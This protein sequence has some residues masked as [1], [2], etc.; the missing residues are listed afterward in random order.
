VAEPAITPLN[1][2]RDCVATPAK[3]VVYLAAPPAPSLTYRV[4]PT[5]E[6]QPADSFSRMQPVEVDSRSQAVVFANPLPVTI[7]GAWLEVQVLGLTPTPAT[8]FVQVRGELSPPNEPPVADKPPAA[9]GGPNV[10][11]PRGSNTLDWLATNQALFVVGLGLLALVVLGVVAM[12]L[13]STG[14]MGPIAAAA[15]GV[16]GS[17]TGAFFGVHAGLGDRE[18]VDNE[19]RL[20]ATKGQMLAAMVPSDDE[21]QRTALKI[22]EEYGPEMTGGGAPRPGD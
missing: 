13:A 22:M 8:Y 17:V 7:P 3:I 21:S 16:I 12:F 2:I 6:A 19:R 14:D 10:R 11:K 5:A 18:R 9:A 15:F 1:A 4:R 20:E